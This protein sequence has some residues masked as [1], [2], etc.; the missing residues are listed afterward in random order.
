MNE[1]EKQKTITEL[2]KDMG[3]LCQT[4]YSVRYMKYRLFESLGERVNI[5]NI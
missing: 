2:C 4:L 1:D 5:S 3:E